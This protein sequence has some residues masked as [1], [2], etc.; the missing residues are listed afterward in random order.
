M[1]GFDCPPVFLDPFVFN[2]GL[3]TC[4][5]GVYDLV[6]FESFRQLNTCECQ[7]CLSVWASPDRPHMTR[8][9]SDDF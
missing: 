1:I 5:R 4:R 8:P 7:A 6:V 9:R 2:N 3:V